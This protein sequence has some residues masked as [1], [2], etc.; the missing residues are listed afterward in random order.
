[1][2]TVVKHWD[3][4]PLFDSRENGCGGFL[5]AGVKLGNTFFW[6]LWWLSLV[7]KSGE[8]GEPPF[9]QHFPVD[10]DIGGAWWKVESGENP[11]LSWWEAGRPLPEATGVNWV[12]VVHAHTCIQILCLHTKTH[13]HAHTHTHMHAH[14]YT[15]T[16]AHTHIFY[17]YIG[18]FRLGYPSSLILMT[19][20]LQCNFKYI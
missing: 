18:D 12:Q 7:F 17:L 3:C 13:T 11:L 1:M 2:V 15:H 8:N 16:N 19:L 20:I 6:T 14:T 5:G 10:G 9:L 4:F